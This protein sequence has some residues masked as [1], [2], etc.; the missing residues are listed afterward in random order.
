MASSKSP[1]R[2]RRA[3]FR[4]H[5]ARPHHGTAPGVERVQDSGGP[6]RVDP[7]VA[8]SGCRARAG[9]AIRFP[10]PYRIAVPPHRLAS[11]ES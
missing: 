4:G 8:Q 6:K 7:A 1:I 2:D 9:A 11:V 3:G 10:E 5:V